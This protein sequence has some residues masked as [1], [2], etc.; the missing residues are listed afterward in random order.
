MPI[1][2]AISL[3]NRNSPLIEH[4]N[5]FHDHRIIVISTVTVIIGYI[6]FSYVYSFFY[7]RF[8]REN[9][10]LELFWTIIPGGILIFI[11]LPSLKILYLADEIN[12]PSISLKTIG[13]QWY[14]SYEYSDFKNLSFDCFIINNDTSRLLETSNHLILPAKTP[15]RLIVTSEDV[16]HSW[17]I[18][19]LGIKTDAIPG[20]LN[21]LTFVINRSGILAGQ[22]SEICG[23]NHSFIPILISVIPTLDF[24]TS[25]KSL[26]SSGW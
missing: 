10:E 5:F 18:S 23:A 26:F 7:N 19:S 15:I 17:T 3:Q 2:I 8:N 6:I 16:I 4:L 25:V 12:D 11:A 22:C 20:R 1:W 14:W 9:Q 21:Q 13:H 24:L